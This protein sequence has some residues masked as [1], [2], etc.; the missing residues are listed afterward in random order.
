MAR[1]LVSRQQAVGGRVDPYMSVDNDSVSV[2]PFGAYPTDVLT[3]PND[4]IVLEVYNYTNDFL[5]PIYRPSAYTIDGYN[6]AI[7]VEKVLEQSRYISGKYNLRARFL[8]NFLGAADSAKMVITEISSDRLE[9]RLQPRRDNYSD[10]EGNILDNAFGIDF[11]ALE[12]SYVLP[13][14]YVYKT[15]FEAY[16]VFDYVQDTITTE[17]FPH[18]II[19]KLTAPL[20][21]S[22]QVD[23]LVWV[24]QEVAA[25]LTDSITIIPPKP[26]VSYTYIA[27]PNYDVLA[28]TITNGATEYR[29][30]DDVLSTNTDTSLAII[31]KLFSG[32]LVEGVAL[33]VDYKKF[34]NFVHF[35]SVEERL[36]NFKYKLELLEF[37]DARINALSQSYAT[38][39]AFTANSALTG[40]EY[41]VSNVL[42]AKN[43]KSAILGGF[44]GYENYLYYQSSSYESSSFGEFTPSTWPKSNSTRPYIN[45]S[46]T[47]SQGIE[48][49]NG[50]IS[51]ASIYDLSNG[52]SL[53]Q[54]I[55]EHIYSNPTNDQYVLFVDMMGHYFDIIYQYVKQITSIHER[56]ESVT[57]GFAKDL[58]YTIGKNLGL[59][60][61]NGNQFDELWSYVLGTNQDSSLLSTTYAT[62]TGDKT[63]E[64]WK[65][66]I[67]NLPYLLRTK[68]T[69]RGIRAL[70]NCYGIPST[71]LRV[72]EYGGP[73]P[74]FYTSSQLEYDQ[75]YY[76]L[77]VGS[78]SSQITIPVANY[79]DSDGEIGGYSALELRFR[80]DTSI[81]SENQT[82]DLLSGPITITMNPG[83]GIITVGSQTFSA[84]IAEPDTDW[85][86][87]LVNAGSKAY[88]GANRY[89]KAVIYS[90]S[91]SPG[92]ITSPSTAL[93]PGSSGGTKFYGLV[94]EFRLWKNNLDL[95]SF[96]N[97]V[98]AGTSFQGS[99]SADNVVG[100]TSSFDELKVRFTLGSDGKKYN[101]ATTTSITSSHPDQTSLR[102][103]STAVRGAAFSGYT[104]NSSSYWSPQI[105]TQYLEYVDGGANRNVGNKIRIENTIAADEQLYREGTIQD[106]VQDLYPIDSA[107]VAVAFS[108]TD[109][110]NEDISEQFGGLN[111]DNYLGDPADYYRDEYTG[112]QGIKN[113]YFKKYQKRNNVQGFIRLTQNYDSSLFQLIKQF[114]PER[115]ALQTGLLI[116]SHLLHR[117]K[118]KQVKPSYTDDTYTSS[119][120]IVRDPLGFVQDM[121]GDE[122]V[123]GGY[124]FETEINRPYSTLGDTTQLEGTM[125]PVPM[126]IPQQNLEETTILNTPSMQ[127]D[128]T[129]PIAYINEYNND[130]ILALNI[131]GI[132]LGNDQPSQYRYFTWFQ[133]GS[134]DNDWRYSS[135]V[136]VDM[137]D[138]IQPIY[139]DNRLSDIYETRIDRF[140]NVFRSN[141][142]RR[143]SGSVFQGEL[144]R[145]LGFPSNA[146]VVP[147][148]TSR[149]GIQA[150]Q[151]G[152]SSGTFNY[153]ILNCF[154]QPS[155][156]L[157]RIRGKITVSDSVGLETLRIQQVNTSLSTINLYG[158]AGNA[159][160][161]SEIGFDFRVF[162][163]ASYPTLRFNTAYSTSTTGRTATLQYLRVER[164]AKA[165]VQDSDMRWAGR[166][167]SYYEGCKLTAADINVNSP[168]TIDGGPVIRVNTVNPTIV[169]STALPLNN[170]VL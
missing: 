67:T 29:S 73:E 99:L 52:A 54:L 128:F 137:Y 80:L 55:P 115:A 168:D 159:T 152:G 5:E 84:S 161:L 20:P 70:V 37:Y 104:S 122:R 61:E 44:D 125:E 113:N 22:L 83:V 59:S 47:S 160:G 131:P 150:T 74:D 77:L 4:S 118:V 7:D 133:T 36:R 169:S 96:E 64:T 79:S 87:V 112:L 69:S 53:R 146:Q 60:T 144:L 58:V 8:R 12:K 3:T 116:E 97:H 24:A 43:K 35:G 21:L 15:I 38:T 82:Y 165:Q 143:L 45:Y 111:L 9:V 95:A 1:S 94:N 162:V 163:S 78:G 157:Y 164:I 108:P 136:G 132:D 18:S 134:G 119:F 130:S 23:D 121:D 149:Y 138:P 68:G 85:W 148:G 2:P 14:L 151:T 48:W 106:S 89:G 49:F 31:Q 30:W 166:R 32:S 10:T 17:D 101:L 103:T 50:I 90:S 40:S 51:S 76:G 105:E 109:E 92:S 13:N 114:V 167:S 42:D 63:K 145:N 72:K 123:P 88:V 66:I 107:R 158:A 27:P 102:Y 135:A 65:R 25:P 28:D 39:P 19:F 127:I 126:S 46:V 156:S 147:L 11:F 81:L 56:Y 91:A 139:W 155:Q 75:F 57:E 110:V 120:S 93:I 34:E 16:K 6:I 124:V 153:N 117:N 170:P 141:N 142:L 33:N 154:T 129:T 62:S 41:Y 98:L 71:I 100:S 140:R 86:Y 26:Q